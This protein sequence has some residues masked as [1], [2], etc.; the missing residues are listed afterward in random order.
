MKRYYYAKEITCPICEGMGIIL[1]EHDYYLC[2]NG[3]E[4]QE[5][6][7][8][9]GK[10]YVDDL[11]EKNTG[12]TVIEL[13]ADVPEVEGNVDHKSYETV[14]DV[15]AETWGI[16]EYSGNHSIF[17]KPHYEFI[18]EEWVYQYNI[19]PY[20]RVKESDKKL[21][22][23]PIIFEGEVCYVICKDVRRRG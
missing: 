4:E 16:I 3:L 19:L 13:E 17:N 8:C 2:D 5:C 14:N 21:I 15:I 23:K 11:V 1:P 22:N 7:N 6:E 18:T 10:G 9:K 20:Y 12:F